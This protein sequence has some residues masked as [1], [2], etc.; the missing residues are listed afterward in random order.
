MR[1]GD[2][3]KKFLS[4]F[5]KL[6]DFRFKMKA[7]C[8]SDFDENAKLAILDQVPLVYKTYYLTIGPKRCKAHGYNV[9]DIRR[10]YEDVKLGI[11]KDKEKRV[12]KEEVDKEAL[13]NHIYN[14]FQ[15]GEFYFNSDIK[16]KLG[17]IYKNLKCSTNPKAT[18]LSNYFKT[19]RATKVI[20]GKQVEGLKILEKL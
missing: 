17:I 8:E 20:D 16:I 3:I 13:L 14:T 7:I 4:D 6:N 15:V 18:D 9:T 2:D 5:E 11:I 12:E 10:E 19:K 1:S